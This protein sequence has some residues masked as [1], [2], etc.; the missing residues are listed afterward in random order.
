MHIVILATTFKA[1]FIAFFNRQ[2]SYNSC[3]EK[4]F[5]INM[6]PLTQTFF[7]VYL[8]VLNVDFTRKCYAIENLCTT[9]F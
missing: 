4:R 8:Y 5:V 1:M 7:R 2:L 3:V 6:P 9:S